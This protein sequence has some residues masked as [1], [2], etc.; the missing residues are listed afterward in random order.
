MQSRTTCPGLALPTVGWALLHQLAVKKIPTGQSDGSNSSTEAPSSQVFLVRVLMT[1]TSTHKFL[2][3]IKDNICAHTL[4]CIWGCKRV[5]YTCIVK[6]QDI[7]MYK[8]I[9]W[10]YHSY[11]L[12]IAE[13]LN[14]AVLTQVILFLWIVYIAYATLDLDQQREKWWLYTVEILVCL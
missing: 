7:H 10:A 4:V 8:V 3:V 9:A 2:S 6:S 12:L 13:P 11:L 1:Q 14:N 5:H